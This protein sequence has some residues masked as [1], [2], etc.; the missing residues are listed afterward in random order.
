MRTARPDG[1]TSQRLFGLDF[2]DDETLDPVVDSVL[3]GI[4]R[5]GADR[6]LVT[7]NVDILVQLGADPT[8]A[9]AA[10]VRSAHW[11][12]PD[13]APVVWASRLLGRP[14]R[15]RLAGSDLFAQLWPELVEAQVPVFVLAS[16]DDVAESLRRSHPLAEVIVAPSI[17]V[18][19]PGALGR[20]A[21]E[22]LDALARSGARLAIMSLGYPKDVLLAERVLRSL[23][24]RSGLTVLCLGGSAE[25]YFGHR[26]RAPLWLQR[27]GGEWLYRLG[28][29]PGRLW[30][31]YLVQ[32]MAFVPLVWA[33]ARTTTRGR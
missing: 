28:Q 30:R 4:H 23:E 31:R 15:A 13:G 21:D 32:D 14:L 8:S 19:D 9:A 26:R 1:L 27:C 25:M 17:D 5:P 12:L 7:P 6:L 24:R 16:D 20:V 29:D 3:T 33:E 18:G 10:T 2:I 11:V 22:C